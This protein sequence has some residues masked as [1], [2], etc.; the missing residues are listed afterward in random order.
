MTIA[1]GCDVLLL[2]H[3]EIRNRLPFNATY[4]ISDQGDM[5]AWNKG[6]RHLQYYFS[7]VVLFHSALSTYD[8][9]LAEAMAERTQIDPKE[10]Q[11]CLERLRSLIIPSNPVAIAYQHASINLLL[12]RYPKAL[13]SLWEAGETKWDEFSALMQKHKLFSQALDL[14]EPGSK[15][16]SVGQ[17]I[18]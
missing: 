16:F 17:Y 7:P 4:S 3:Y 15:Q 11:P 9:D 1:T 8:L 14:A 6:L 2:S 18:Y 12:E 13:Q 10:Y 5:A